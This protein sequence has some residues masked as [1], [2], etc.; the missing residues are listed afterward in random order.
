MPSEQRSALQE[1]NHIRLK[2]E[3]VDSSPMCFESEDWT[4][5]G[6][7]FQLSNAWGW[8]RIL[9][10]RG[11]PRSRWVSLELGHFFRFAHTTNA[12]NDSAP[13]CGRPWG[14]YNC[15]FWESRIIIFR[16][17]FLYSMWRTRE[18]KTYIS[19]PLSLVIP[20]DEKT[21]TGSR[22]SASKSIAFGGLEEVFWR[23]YHSNGACRPDIKY[24]LASWFIWKQQ[25]GMD[26][27]SLWGISIMQDL[28]RRQFLR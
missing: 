13:R 28:R 7:G 22:G 20:Q 9:K 21:L 26:A 6:I 23:T 8:V 27:R 1:A 2:I 17:N 5:I 3:R 11:P 15:V 12:T 16:Q 10:A 24:I 4:N 18:F 14:T 19:G 25:A